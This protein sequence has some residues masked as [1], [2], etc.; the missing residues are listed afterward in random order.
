MVA[1][2]TGMWARLA[3]RSKANFLDFQVPSGD[4]EPKSF[5][6]IVFML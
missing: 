1:F 2:T 4:G 5:R 3:V 6:R